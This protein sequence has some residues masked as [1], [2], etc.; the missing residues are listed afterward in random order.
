MAVGGVDV[1]LVGL[2]VFR[3]CPERGEMAVGGGDLVLV[4]LPVF[5]EFLER[6]EM[7]ICGVDVVFVGQASSIVFS[8]AST[9]LSRSRRV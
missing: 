4:R 1:V 6:G 7:A 2:A 5:G 9:S 3:D 8:V